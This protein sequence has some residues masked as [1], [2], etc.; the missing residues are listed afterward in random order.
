MYVFIFQTLKYIHTKLSCS[1]CVT[2]LTLWSSWS[3]LLQG[4]WLC[5]CSVTIDQHQMDSLEKERQLQI[6]KLHMKIPATMTCQNYSHSRKT[7]Y[8]TLSDLQLPVQMHKRRVLLKLHI[9]VNDLHGKKTDSLYLNALNFFS[10]W[11]V[12]QTMTLEWYCAQFNL[13]FLIYAHIF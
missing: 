10:M 7:Q 5:N 12:K 4:F 1:D 6:N 13:S 3:D 2:E 11:N 9:T 8:E